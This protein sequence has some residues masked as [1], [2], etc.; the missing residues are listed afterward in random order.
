MKALFLAGAAALAFSVSASADPWVDYTPQKGLY[1]VIGVKVDP[2]KIDDY[3]KGLKK[4]WLP[5]EELAKKQGIIDSYEI[6]INVNAANP[7][8]NVLLIEHVTSFAQLDPNKKRD[9][10]I[11]KAIEAATP[12]SESDAMVSGFDK[13]RVFTSQDMWQAIE[14]TK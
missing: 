11:Q 3:L 12:K 1:S 4:V 5:G 2:N 8:A 14:F 9:L 13:Y 6:L 7:G 10:E